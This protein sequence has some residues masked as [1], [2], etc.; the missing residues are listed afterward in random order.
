M[1][2][3]IETLVGQWCYL[4][5]GVL[6]KVGLLS[7]LWRSSKASTSFWISIPFLSSGLKIW[8]GKVYTKVS[9][10]LF[11]FFQDPPPKSL[12]PYKSFGLVRSYT[13]EDHVKCTGEK[14]ALSRGACHCERL[15]AAGDPVGEEQTCHNPTEKSTAKPEHETEL[16]FSPSN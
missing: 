2:S 13:A 7:R 5:D 9:N 6:G 15:P 1:I 12:C 14:S 4:E 8:G 11:Y 16:M 10:R 3:S